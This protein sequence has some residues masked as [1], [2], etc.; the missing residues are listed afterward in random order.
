MTGCPEICTNEY[1]PVCGSDGTTY[2]NICVMLQTDCHSEGIANLTVDY[3]GEC[4]GKMLQKMQSSTYR[5]FLLILFMQIL[6][7]I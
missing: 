6:Y 4:K 3:D 1:S 2:S 7:S 5:F